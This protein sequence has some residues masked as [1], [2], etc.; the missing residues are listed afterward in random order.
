MLTRLR[1]YREYRRQGLRR[2]WS[3]AGMSP[4]AWSVAK[5]VAA[6]A[7]SIAA[8]VL[9]SHQAE[10]INLAADNRVAAKV[11]TQAGE[12]E[13]LRRLLAACLGDKEGAIFIGGELHL[14]RAVPTGVRQ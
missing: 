11:A 10:A 13:Q 8:A 14:C 3:Y 2:A 7:L 4:V 6:G 12:I 5:Y 1:L 9:A